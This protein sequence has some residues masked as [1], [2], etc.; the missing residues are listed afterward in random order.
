M[1]AGVREYIKAIPKEHRPL[2]DRIQRLVL[3]AHPEADLM[4]SYKMPSFKLGQ[5]RLY[6][7]VWKHG[8]S[9]YGWQGNRDGGFTAR[10]PELKTGK[11]TIQLRPDDATRIP[12]D[13]FRDLARAALNP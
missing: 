7:G 13:E 3:E 6:L 12:D 2:F 11:G 4:L 8:I 5:R 10:H 1:D 9:L